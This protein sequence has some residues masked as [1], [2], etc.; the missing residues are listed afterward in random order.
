MA[1]RRARRKRRSSPLG[2]AVARRIVRIPTEYL[3][4]IEAGARIFPAL[5]QLENGLRL[6][7]NNYLVTCYGENWWEISLRGKLPQIVRYAEDQTSRRDSMPWIGSSTS[8]EVLPIHLVTLGHLEEIVKSYRS[9]CI[10]Q[11][12]PTL[13]FFLGHME[14]V[15][16][17]RN[18]FAHMFPCITR[19]DF[20]LARREIQ[21]LA[22]HINA[23]L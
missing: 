2:A 19:N 4:A 21:T 20:T 15:K 18:L 8:I 10:P 6:A 12:F 22:A 1:T 16:R 23:R 17:V 11:L 9:D 14:V 7:I 13:E 5:F 3:G